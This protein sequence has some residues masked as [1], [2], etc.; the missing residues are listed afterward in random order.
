MMG[1]SRR[2]ALV[3]MAALLTVVARAE[4]AAS[5]MPP[6]PWPPLGEGTVEIVNGGTPRAI[7]VIAENP[8]RPAQIAAAEFIA[9]VRKITGVEL[10]L[11]VDAAVPR[12]T[13]SP[14]RVLIGESLL[15][16]AYG[17][18]NEDFERQECLV[19]T[20][21]QDLILMGRDAEE[22]GLISYEKNGLWPTAGGDVIFTAM[23]SLHAVHELLQRSWGVR[24]YLPG[25]IGEVVQ[26]QDRLLV[27]NLNIR[28]RPWTKYRGSSRLNQ[29]QAAWFYGSR[30]PDEIRAVDSREMLQWLLRMRI[31]GNP[32]TA[33]HAFGSYSARF[34]D[35]HPEWWKEGKPTPAW[36]HPDYLSPS[37]I[38][39]ISND[40]IDYFD[41]KFP[42]GLFPDGGGHV[43][44]AGDFYSVSPNDG[45][46]GLIWTEAGEALRRNEPRF[47]DG[48]SCGWATDFVFTMANDVARRVHA[49][50]PD[51]WISCLVY[52]P[53]FQPP[54][55][56]VGL[57]P[58]I[59]ITQAANLHDSFTEESWRY[60]ADNLLAWSKLTGELYVW[61]WYLQQSF[62]D[63]AAFPP[64][65]PR[66]IARAI[67]YMHECG[68]DGM[69]FEASAA[70]SASGPYTDNILANPLEDLL[71]HYVT[72]KLLD[73]IDLDVDAMLAEHYRLFYGPAQRPMAAYFTLIED[74][75]SDPETHAGP[76]ISQP[77]RY[78]ERMGTPETVTRLRELI[79][80]AARLATEAP[81]SERVALAE[82]ALQ[83]QIE[84]RAARYR[85]RHSARPRLAAAGGGLAEAPESSAFKTVTLQPAKSPCVMRAAWDETTVTLA[86]RGSGHA[87]RLVQLAVDPGRGRERAFLA[88]IG[89]AESVAC[90]VIDRKG[91]RKP[92]PIDPAVHWSTEEEN[93]WALEVTMDLLLLGVT[94][95]VPGDVWGLQAICSFDDGTL[96]QWAPTLE[97][98]AQLDEYGVLA[99]QIPPISQDDRP[100]AALHFSFDDWQN[101]GLRGSGYLSAS[102]QL[103]TFKD[104]QSWGEQNLT[105]GIAGDAIRLLGSEGA[106]YLTLTAPAELNLRTDDFTILLW[107]RGDNPGGLL[108]GSTTTSPYWQY[109]IRG[110]EGQ[111]PRLWMSLNAGGDLATATVPGNPVEAIADGQWHQLALVVDRGREVRFLVDGHFAGSRPIADQR[112]SLKQAITIGGPYSWLRGDIDELSIY[113]GTLDADAIRAIYALHRP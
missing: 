16:K 38:E 24:W 76:E 43:P 89:D 13:W 107:Y 31:G 74:R 90:N 70:P 101:G 35:S 41:G 96:L 84:R 86:L 79:D 25:E 6:E 95:I 39:Q 77:M 4:L 59:S 93:Q 9:Y 45:R 50:H 80:E 17:L 10:P 112:G 20:R 21:G 54:S 19:A 104:G 92:F 29:R 58:N 33:G 53:Y 5:A 62:A 78:W 2:G 68:V 108:L 11:V 72:W 3:A 57:A 46:K 7:V 97:G 82:A 1:G 26:R 111:P 55:P 51:K 102:L 71:N 83:Q 49:R 73:D 23:G 8:T 94:E 100:P 85:T 22:Y 36:P 56:E 75:W 91:A 60:H 99:F 18:R 88:E 30:Q 103:S 37:L 98:I 113:A 81:Y 15:T 64:I 27:T 67:R 32:H 42:K 106:Q 12:A 66:N 63:H 105:D 52:G 69:F 40:A 28:R 47:Q 14:R 87:P 44:A 34:G 109:S 61:E 48:F 65:F 110:D